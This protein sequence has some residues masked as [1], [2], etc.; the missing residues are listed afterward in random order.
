MWRDSESPSRR[1]EFDIASQLKLEPKVVFPHAGLDIVVDVR[2][3][4][5]TCVLVQPLTKSLWSAMSQG[6]SH[7]LRCV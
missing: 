4:T 2:V 5:C 6:N 7:D 1:D 3:Q